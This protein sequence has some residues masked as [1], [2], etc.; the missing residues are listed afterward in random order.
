MHALV[1]SAFVKT[2]L[3]V[4]LTIGTMAAADFTGTWKFNPAKSQY[5]RDLSEEMLTIKQTGPDSYTCLGSAGN[6]EAAF[7]V[8]VG[9]A[10]SGRGFS[11][12]WGS[13]VR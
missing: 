13:I 9:S 10:P 8:S 11:R 12:H 3:P 6:G 4:L 1:R 7:F 5:R 2:V